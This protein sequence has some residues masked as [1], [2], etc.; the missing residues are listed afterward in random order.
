MQERN[1]RTDKQADRQPD[2]REPDDRH[3][4]SQTTD[5]QTKPLNSSRFF[6]ISRTNYREQIS[7]LK[8]RELNLIFPVPVP[9]NGNGKIKKLRADLSVYSFLS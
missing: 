2:D 9:K 6:E 8:I 3:T 4:D 7:R 1:G 5:R